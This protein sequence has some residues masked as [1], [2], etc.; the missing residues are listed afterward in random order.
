MSNVLQEDGHAIEE[1]KSCLFRPEC[2]RDGQAG[3][4]GT[5]L[6][7]HLSNSGCACAHLGPKRLQIPVPDICTDNLYPRPEG[8]CSF[9]F[10][11]APRQYLDPTLARMRGELVSQARFADAGLTGE[12]E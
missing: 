10:I 3:E 5:H 9:P 7:N 11:T 6:R 8:R 1:A 12:E 4:M 2:W